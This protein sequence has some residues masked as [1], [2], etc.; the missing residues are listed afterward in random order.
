MYGAG[1]DRAAIRASLDIQ[2][3][4]DHLG[5]IAHNAHSQ[6]LALVIFEAVRQTVTIVG[7]AHYNLFTGFGQRDFDAL[8]VAVA[9]GVIHGF[10]GDA[11]EV[12]S[13]VLMKNMDRLFTI[14]TA[15]DAKITFDFDGPFFQS[16]HQPIRIGFDRQQS[17]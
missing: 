6:T 10:L 15:V 8:A 1:Y 12:G 2:R 16:R 14:K 11:V 9:D 17:A 5:A 4:A 7:N 13:N 3:A